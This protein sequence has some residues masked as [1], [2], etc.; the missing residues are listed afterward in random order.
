[1]KENIGDKIFK[2][3]PDARIRQENNKYLLV[4][5]ATQ[6]LHFISNTAYQLI[7]KLD[8]KRTV[9]SIINELWPSINEVQKGAIYNF[10]EK[11]VERRIL[12]EV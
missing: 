10:V 7:E 6:G 1:M 8:G 12:E 9:N 4:N 2:L 3:G 11:I 5:I